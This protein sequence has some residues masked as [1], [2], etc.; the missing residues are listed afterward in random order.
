MPLMRVCL[1]H[2]TRYPQG[3]RCPECPPK[4]GLDTQARKAQAEFRRMLLASSDGQ[5]AYSDADGVRCVE[6]EGL[7]AAHV[8]G[9]YADTGAFAAGVLCCPAHHRLLDHG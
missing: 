5:C 4:R 1:T 7:Q 9:R 6:V 3:E 2:R 8:G